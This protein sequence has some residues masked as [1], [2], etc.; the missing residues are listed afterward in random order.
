MIIDDL[1]RYNSWA[2]HR[3]DALCDG[4]TDA[5]LDEPRAMG[6]GSLRNTIFHVLT[7]EEIWFERWS[8][9]PWRPFPTAAGGLSIPDMTQRLEQVATERQTLIDRERADGWRRI[10]EYKDSK[11]T[12]YRQPLDGLLLHVA[13]HGIYHRAQA[14][15]FLKQFG[16][17][18]PGGIDFLFFRLAKPCVEQEPAT[19]NALRQSGMEVATG[20]SP[21]VAWEPRVIRNYFAYGD[22]CNGRVLDLAAQLDAPALDRDFQM[23]VGTIRKTA[24]HIADAE[25]WWLRNW[26]TGPTA[27]EKAPVSTTIAEL[28]SHWTQIK[29]D[30]NRFID[31][32]D[33]TSAQRV[34]TALDRPDV[35]AFSRRSN[36]SSN[37]AVT[38]RIIVLSSSTCCVT[39]GWP[40]LP[41]TILSGCAN[42]P[43]PE[44]FGVSGV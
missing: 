2:N 11:G 41:A 42:R 27:F 39:A 37:S 21:P 5:Q 20:S 7:A 13:N 8:G 38:A 12:T 31:S 26:T 36:R 10:C 16:R 32:L 33:E 44:L 15:N 28:R 25:R 35:V 30:R 3:I 40:V 6:L 34:V 19:A 9:V 29:T 1:Y 18:V 14:L 43:R 23:G 4:L 17:T 22:W 24:L